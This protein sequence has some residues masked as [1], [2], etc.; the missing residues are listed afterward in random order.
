MLIDPNRI[1]DIFHDCL[2]RDDEDHS[3][4]ISAEG[5]TVKVGFHPER[6]NS[7][8]DEVHEILL[9]LPDS[10]QEGKGGGMSFLYMCMDKEEEQCMEQPTAQEL[11][12][13][14]LGTGWV[15][16]PLP[17]ALWSVLPG[18]VP[19]VMVNSERKQISVVKG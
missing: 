16:L 8:A 4:F 6:L 11:M 3:K 12:L 14:G 1:H 7:Y 13:L 2:F 17:R 5:L 19:Y 9:N 15:T 18:G 10:F